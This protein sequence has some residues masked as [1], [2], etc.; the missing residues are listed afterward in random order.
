[1]GVNDSTTIEA[2][3][4]RDWLRKVFAAHRMPLHD[5]EVAANALVKASL[6]G[7]DSHGVARTPMYCERMRR[8]VA[9]PT[10]EIKVTRVSPAVSLVDGDNGIGLVVGHRA[11]AEA[12]SIA[13]EYGIGLA[14][15]KR[16]GHY[17]MG[18]LYVLQAI[19]SGCVGLAFTN[20]SPA[21]P[22]W[23]GRA[24]FLGT[25]PFAAGAPT[26]AGSPFVLDMACSIVARGKLKFAAQRGEA[27]PE[28]LALDR[29]GRPT[30]DGAAAFEG[31]V[32]PMGGVKGAGLSL[33]M[34]VLSG[35]FTGA[36]FGG[37]VRNPFT[38]LDGPQGTG[39]FFMALRADLF[40]PMET[41][42]K[43][44]RTL[45]GR[46]KKQPLAQGFDEIL[47]PG[48]PESRTERERLVSGI[49]LTRDVLESLQSEGKLAGIPF[50]CDP[51]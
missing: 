31:V 45:A 21:L 14:G 1:M 40:M 30:T 32:L 50:S 43:R 35:V 26:G 22:V 2:E 27:I 6:R 4:L 41:F 44:M 28:G 33:L 24:K 11:M 10:P 48:E 29:Q 38:G 37:E 17:G 18:A 49:P 3:E 51:V 15:V 13:Q 7:V 23:G 36:A 9:N 25:S 34:E 47:M 46:V 20:A 12:I 8:K 42:E 16:S 5:A 39:H 19:E